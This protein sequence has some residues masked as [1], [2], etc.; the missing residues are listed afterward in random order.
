MAVSFLPD[1]IVGAHGRDSFFILDG[2][3]IIM[4]ASTRAKV[5]DADSSTHDWRLKTICVGDS[6]LFFMRDSSGS[7]TDIGKIKP[8]P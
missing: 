5:I 7:S 4:S 3:Q 6:P 1:D 8:T 2:N